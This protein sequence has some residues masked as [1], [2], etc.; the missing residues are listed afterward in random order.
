MN[1]VKKEFKSL[2]T[3]ASEQETKTRRDAKV[4]SLEKELKW[5]T[6]EALRLD[7]LCKRYKQELEKW[8]H[9]R[10][11]CTCGVFLVRALTGFGP[12]D[13]VD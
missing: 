12:L 7:D 10:L 11:G 13:G 1:T 4:S 6:Q 8:K 3:K 5:F 9:R 2:Q